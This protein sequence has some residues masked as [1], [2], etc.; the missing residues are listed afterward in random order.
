MDRA[1]R[2]TVWSVTGFVIVAALALGAASA[3]DDAMKKAE[4]KKDDAMA[5]GMKPDQRFVV[6][7]ATDGMLEV[8]LGQLAVERG[9]MC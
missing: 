9:A 8:K 4:A 6:E 5:A 1:I 3:Q 7:A 2:A